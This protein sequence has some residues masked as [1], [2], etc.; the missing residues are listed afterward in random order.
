[1]KIMDII[2][3]MEEISSYPPKSIFLSYFWRHS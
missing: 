1:M 2:Y 3:G